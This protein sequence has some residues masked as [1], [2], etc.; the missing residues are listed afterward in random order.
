MVGSVSRT[1]IDWVIKE[2]GPAIRRALV[3]ILAIKPETLLECTKKANAYKEAVKHCL[4]KIGTENERGEWEMGNKAYKELDPW[5]F[6][7]TQ[8]QREE[9]IEKAIGAYDRLRIDPKDDIWQQLLPPS[10]RN[11]GKTLSRLNLQPSQGTPSMRPNIIDRKTGHPKRPEVKKASNGAA[12]DKNAGKLSPHPTKEKDVTKPSRSDSPLLKASTKN[13]VAKSSRLGQSPAQRPVKEVKASTSAKSLLN[14]PRNPSPLS[15]SPPVNASDFEDTHPVHRT[16]S[17]APSPSKSGSTG[18]VKRK[19]QD[20]DRHREPSSKKARVDNLLS[21]SK[22]SKS[23]SSLKRKS[24][25]SSSSSLD[26]APL[27]LRKLGNSNADNVVR[28]RSSSSKTAAIATGK[29]SSKRPRSSTQVSDD[30]SVTS[31]D[32]VTSHSKRLEL[33]E[34]FKRY[35]GRYKRF[36]MELSGKSEPPSKDQLATLME[37]H[38]RVA[39]MKKQL[40]AS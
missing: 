14:K 21:V 33:A 18:S 26:S 22:A 20:V 6:A 17:A 27:K 34:D 40:A 4:Q 23:S 24:E 10:D 25:D 38:N 11:K 32:Y 1:T 9:I 12:K 35:Y 30:S 19:A 39:D 3:H 15:K 13:K 16:F 8:S 29:P 36:H 28:A 31:P 5:T 7:Y 2:K 37:M